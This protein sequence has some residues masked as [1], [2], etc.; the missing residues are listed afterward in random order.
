[1]TN[2][3]SEVSAI[4]EIILATIFLAASSVVILGTQILVIA[5]ACLLLVLWRLSDVHLGI[6]SY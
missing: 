4:I 1:M 5:P 6:L 2:K 3:Y